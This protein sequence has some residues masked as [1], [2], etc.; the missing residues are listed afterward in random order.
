[1][2]LVRNLS[3][4]GSST[5]IAVGDNRKFVA[6]ITTGKP[7]TFLWTFDLQHHHHLKTTLVGQEVSSSSPICSQRAHFLQ[8]PMT[9]PLF[10]QLRRLPAHLQVYYMPEEPGLLTVYLRALNAL[11][12]QNVTQHIVVQQQLKTAKLTAL[13][14]DTLVNKLVT[15]KALVS[16]LAAPLDCL[17][18]FGDG[19]SQ[20]R[21]PNTSL[22]HKYTF[23]GHYWIQV[24][25]SL[26]KQYKAIKVKSHT[27]MKQN[28]VSLSDIYFSQ[29]VNCTTLFTFTLKYQNVVKNRNSKLI[30]IYHITTLNITI[31][32]SFDFLPTLE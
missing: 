7:V 4:R 21:S 12:T 11:H 31:F 1:M 6:N 24:G 15:L 28:K 5:A 16:P 18:D 8:L 23:P 2:E 9:F 27:S 20:A 19:S 22:G 10:F 14:R 29:S 30:L 32:E 13:P 26:S 3:I 17:W 25:M